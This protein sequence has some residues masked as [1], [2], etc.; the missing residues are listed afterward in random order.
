MFSFGIV[1]SEMMVGSYPYESPPK[2]TGTFEELIV[3]V[4]GTIRS[5]GLSTCLCSSSQ[6]LRPTLPSSCPDSLR[7]LIV[8]CWHEDPAMRPSMDVVLMRL[9]EIG[10]C[11]LHLC[12]R[13][14]MSLVAAVQ[15]RR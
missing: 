3:S 13:L 4:R 15:T 12:N 2:S 5:S 11:A 1:L 7:E 10:A 9:I 6:G 14:L 8:A